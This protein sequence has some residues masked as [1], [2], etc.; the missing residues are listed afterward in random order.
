M[1]EPLESMGFMGS[2]LGLSFEELPPTPESAAAERV[3]QSLGA[4]MKDIEKAIDFLKKFDPDDPWKGMTVKLESEVAPAHTVT[5]E[6]LKR[7]DGKPKDPSALDKALAYAK[8]TVTI[9]HPLLGSKVVAPAGRA[10][11]D[12]WKTTA[13]VAAGVG[14]GGIVLIGSVGFALGWYLGKK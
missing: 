3:A 13:G 10:S 8:P 9:A 4:S 7:D 14:I 11:K 5:S 1:G 2:A 6:D 12:G